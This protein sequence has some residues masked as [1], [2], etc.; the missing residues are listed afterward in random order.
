MKRQRRYPMYHKTSNWIKNVAITVG[1]MGLSLS[2]ALAQTSAGCQN[3]SVNTWCTPSLLPLSALVTAGTSG[4]TITATFKGITYPNS[5]SSDIPFD[6]SDAG[7]NPVSVNIM[8]GGTSV[9]C[10]SSVKVNCMAPKC[11]INAFYNPA[12]A[13]PGI[14][15]VLGNGTSA[16][17]YVAYIG[18]PGL[19]STLSLMAGA[20]GTNYIWTVTPLT[21]GTTAGFSCPPST[22]TAAAT[23]TSP[24]TTVYGCS[25]VDFVPSAEGLYSVMLTTISQ[26]DPIQDN[27]KKCRTQCSVII[28]VMDLRDEVAEDDGNN[29]TDKCKGKD[30]V[31]ICHFDEDKSKYKNMKVC[32][33]DVAMHLAHGDYLGKCDKPCGVKKNATARIIKEGDIELTVVPN[34]S[35]TDFRISLRGEVATTADIIVYDLAG[36]IVEKQLNQPIATEISVGSNLAPG[37]YVIGVKQDGQTKMIKV[38]KE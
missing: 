21:S 14:A 13:G 32:L 25:T 9:T 17:P 2:S 34:P 1:L 12:M 35:T 38:V 19:T 6:C 15:G 4:K 37:M 36:R 29:E 7:T 20:T 18:Y 5:I 23:T 26:D 27:D 28:C 11:N 10:T 8:G 22:L 31:Q 33:S 30:K 16:K 24:S 3:A